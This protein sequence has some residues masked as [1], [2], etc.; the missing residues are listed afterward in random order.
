[1]KK[2]MLTASALLLATVTVLLLHSC[3]KDT[4]KRTYTF[5]TPVIHTTAELRASIK[6]DIAQPIVNPGK[7]YVK[8]NTIFLTEKEKGIHII[9]NTNPSNPINKAFITIPGNED[10]AVN[11]NMLYADCYTDL[12]AIDISNINN[13]TLKNYVAYL[14]PE[15]RYTNGYYLDSGKIVTEWIKHDT[16][17][18][19]SFTVN[20]GYWNYGG[21][22]FTSA[23]PAANTSAAGS[24][25]GTGG[26][27][28][29]ITI[30]QD[31][32]YSVSQ[33]NLV[34]L[35]ISNPTAPTFLSKNNLHLDIGSA[36]TIYPF[37][38]K[39]F[40]GSSSGMYIF[41]IANPDNPTL[42]KAFTHAS[43]CDPVITDGIN[44]YIT[45]HSGTMCGGIKNELEVVNVSN[46][47]NPFLVKV[48]AMTK[49]YGLAKDGNTLIVCDDALKIYDASNVSDLKLKS[50]I[51]INTPYDVICIN[52]FA[53]VT[54]ADGLYQFD[55][56]D[57]SNV[58]Q[59]SRLSI[60]Q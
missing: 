1:M 42:L 6:N 60:N 34:A 40:I 38:D 29:K 47:L 45:L 44:A 53:I 28:A 36:E 55:Y 21:I 43:A 23:S 51:S 8:D 39:L 2:N 11:G 13:I 50:S 15:R 12:L 26:S 25:T 20:Q 30:I 37:R 19:A 33:D 48:Y 35:N 49:P 52:G 18:D 54:A 41:S 22:Q 5:Y 57:P 14:Y 17:V 58:K 3:L 31:R 56:T 46:V 59:L 10:M 4:G 7:I 27:M 16:T 9:D 24:T 32:L